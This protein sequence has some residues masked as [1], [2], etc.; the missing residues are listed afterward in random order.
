MFDGNTHCIEEHKCDN[1]PIE[2]LRFN[3]MFHCNPE[4]NDDYGEEFN[5]HYFA[6]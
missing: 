1:E 3:G 5:Y 4:K 2:C 6:L